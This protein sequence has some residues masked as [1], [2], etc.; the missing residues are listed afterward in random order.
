MSKIS[1]IQTI[2]G[3]VPDGIWGPKSQGALDLVLRSSA[4]APVWPFSIEFDGDDI[5]V[6][7]V[8]ITC[9]GGWGTGIADSQDKGDTA[10]GLN[11]A[12]QAIV[13]VSIPMDGRDFSSLS[14]AE[15]RSLDGCPIRRLLNS[16]GLTAW[17]TLV[18]VTISGNKPFTPPDGIVDLGPGL[19]ASK[20]GQPH[21]LD[22]TVLAAAYFSNLPLRKL[23]NNFE[24]RGS[25]RI[26][27]G[28]K[29][30]PT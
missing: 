19:Q 21:A 24:A 22:F 23:A 28:A 1:D 2:I 9:F 18:E 30:F 4:S 11:T 6:R 3:V 5:V 16:K 26:L 14:P 17:H 27:G 15:H 20:P 8:V 10:S 13:G 7:D 12:R 25:Y 29:L